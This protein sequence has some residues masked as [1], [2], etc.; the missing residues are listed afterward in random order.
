MKT[1]FSTQTIS[2]TLGAVFIASSALMLSCKDDDKTP[3]ITTAKKEFVTDYTKMVDFSYQNVLAHMN[4]LKTAINTFTNDPSEATHKAAKKAWLDSRVPYGQT[5]VYRFYAGPIDDADGPEGLINA[6]PLDECHI[7]YVKTAEEVCKNGNI[8]SGTMKLTKEYLRKNNEKVAGNGSF[9]EEQNAKAIITGFHAIEFMLWGQDL[10]EYIDSPGKRSY[11]DYT[12]KDGA[13]RRK[14][15]LKLLVDVLIEDMTSVANEWKEGGAYR[16]AFLAMP[17]DDAIL[18]ITTGMGRLTK[19]ELAGERIAA[20]V[21]NGDQEDEHSCFSDNTHV[22]HR[23]NLQGIINIVEG[24]YAAKNP[25]GENVSFTG[26][27]LKE[28]VALENADAAKALDDTYQ[29]AKKAVY[30]MPVPFDQAIKNNKDVLNK[31]VESLGKAATSLQKAT[32]AIGIKNVPVDL[33][34]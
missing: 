2:K 34:E 11:T 27:S 14:E 10:P 21:K 16:K 23:M 26:K 22:D 3:A 25:K 4:N 8:I 15:Y 6:W 7:D 30:A 18:K 5:E 17:E 13:E 33:E 31:A 20:A 28:V 29:A 1:T 19:G 9:N 12:T 24:K 32:E